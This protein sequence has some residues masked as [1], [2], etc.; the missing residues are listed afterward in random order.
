MFYRTVYIC[1]GFLYIK[2]FKNH[3]INNLSSNDQSY[4]SNIITDLSVNDSSVIL[5][6][7]WEAFLVWQIHLLNVHFYI[8]FLVSVIGILALCVCSNQTLSQFS[9]LHIP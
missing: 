2:E 5:S 3:G 8:L 9:T 7:M 4:I 1:V 6:Q